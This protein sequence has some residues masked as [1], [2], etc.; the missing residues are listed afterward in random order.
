MKDML[1]FNSFLV[2]SLQPDGGLQKKKI[3]DA[4]FKEYITFRRRHLAELIHLV[5]I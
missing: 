3:Y 1:L 2:G 4:M 5:Y